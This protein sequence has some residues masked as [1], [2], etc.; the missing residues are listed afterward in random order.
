MLWKVSAEK[1]SREQQLQQLLGLKYLQL[2]Q[3]KMKYLLKIVSKKIL[4]I[5]KTFN[6]LKPKEV[7]AKQHLERFVRKRNPE[8]IRLRSSSSLN[9]TCLV[10]LSADD[11]QT[12]HPLHYKLLLAAI[13]I[14]FAV[15]MS[16]Y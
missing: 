16:M 14:H 5:H 1:S 7:I 6:N 9:L 4:N 15:I 8:I 3:N 2:N 13:T 11:K 12:E 10:V